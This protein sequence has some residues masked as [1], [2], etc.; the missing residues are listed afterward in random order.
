[1]NADQFTDVIVPALKTALA[2]AAEQPLYKIAKQPGLFASRTGPSGEAAQRALADGLL[3]VVRTESKGKADTEWVRIT[4]R[5]VQFVCQHESPKEALEEL[6]AVLRTGRSG[7]PAWLEE[8]RASL[9][10]VVNRFTELFERQHT[11]WEQLAQRAEEALKRLAAPSPPT[12]LNTWQLDALTFLDQWKA[13]GRGDCPLSRLFAAVRE[14]T[15]Q[16]GIADFHS[17]LRQLRDRS[18]VELVSNDSQADAEP[19][20]ALLEGAAVHH[21]VRRT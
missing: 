14:R 19:E 11:R 10:G 13:A 2:A 16:L 4:P 7:M 18:S 6:L 9:Q 1:M 12:D 21:A 20:F 15:S 17:G 5:G 3:E 8:L